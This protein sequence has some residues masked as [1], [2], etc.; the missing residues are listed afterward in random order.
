MYNEKP[1]YTL[2]R[3]TCTMSQRQKQERPIME[4]TV[5]LYSITFW[6]A[7]AFTGFGAFLGLMGIWIPEFWKSET[8]VKMLLTNGIFAGTSVLIAAM[9]KWLS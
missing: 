7:I 4:V 9:T 6:A 1:N 2:M 5:T 3:C 8:A